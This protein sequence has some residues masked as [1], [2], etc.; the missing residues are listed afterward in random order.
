VLRADGL[1][2]RY[3][4]VVAVDDVS[5]DVGPGELLALLGTNGAGKSSTLRAL[6]GLVPHDGTVT[7]DGAPVGDPRHAR[8]AGIV[9]WPQGRG[10]F[11]RLTVEQ[12]V[13]MGAYALDRPA[14]ADAIVEA[15]RRITDVNG[16][17]TRRVS[18]LSGGEQALVALARLLAGRPRVALLDEPAL[19]LAPLVVGRLFG[20]IAALRA[21]G[22]AVVLVEQY[23]ERALDV[24]DRVVVLERGRAAYSGSVAGVGRAEDLLAGYL[25][26]PA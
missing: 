15:R 10:L 17:W 9:H 20:E 11:T 8:R 21:D 18:T 26:R 6:S 19:G 14:R 25:G 24:A 16:W 1:G 4:G 12:N 22:V 2:V 23:A 13:A 5:V 3:G 7:V